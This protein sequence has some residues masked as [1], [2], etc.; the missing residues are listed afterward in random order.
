MKLFE[1]FESPL[2]G[3]AQNLK[4][5]ATAV[6][7]SSSAEIDLAGES[8]TLEYP[9]ARFVYGLYKQALQDGT[10]DRFMQMLSDPQ[11]FD[12]VMSK[13]G[14]MLYRDRGPE[15]AQAAAQRIGQPGVQ[16]AGMDIDQPVSSG[17]ENTLKFIVKSFPKEIKDFFSSG[18]LDSDLYDRL[19]DY[20]MM[21]GE[22]P[23][24][25]AK[26]RTGDPHNWIAGR[27]QQ[28]AQPYLHL[29]ESL[30]E[31]KKVV[32]ERWDDEDDD[33]W[34]LKDKT[35]KTSMGTTVTQ[36]GKGVVHK[37]KYGSEYQGDD[38][39]DDDYD[40]WGK[41]KPAAKKAR[42]AAKV[43]AVAAEPKRSRGRP[44]A[45]IKSSDGGASV[46]DYATW[47][48]KVKRS[49]EGARVVGSRNKAVA[50]VQKG[51]KNFVAGEWSGSSGDIVSKLAKTVSAA[52]LASDFK[53][54]KGRPKKVRE[55]IENLR[56]V[57]E[58]KNH[59]GETEYNT[60]S[61]WKA[62]CKKAGADEFEGDRDI[63]QAKKGGK[64]VG[65]WDGAVGTVYDDAHKKAKK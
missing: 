49:H 38:G 52:S 1:L 65:E 55:F 23:Y 11:S 59:M 10:Q 46:N 25:V 33:W 16:E 54:A 12:R 21:H 51:N 53:S 30:T 18:E 47:Y 39:D 31:G 4:A 20:Y 28:D 34:G 56:Y 40:E 45:A 62:A 42:A 9:E 43:A 35:R 8:V 22:M 61:G 14:N 36:T 15:M 32:A 7:N 64:G 48:R 27:F 63:C 6:A 5:I 3:G 24:G 50:V 26:G 19:F 41:L 29:H 37:G 13:M 57:V 58:A 17:N 44:S 60:Y 2:L